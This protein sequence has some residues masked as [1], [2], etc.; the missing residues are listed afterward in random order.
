MA[1]A[2]YS[3]PY[4]FESLVLT[5]K[6]LHCTLQ[7]LLKRHNELRKKYRD[8]PGPEAD[9]RSDSIFD[10]LVEITEHPIIADYIINLDL[11]DF[12][13]HNV[14]GPDE[15][16]FLEMSQKISTLIL[17]SRHLAMLSDGEDGLGAKWLRE[18]VRYSF[19]PGGFEGSNFGVG[20][21]LS[22]LSNVESIS[23]P[24][25]WDGYSSLETG[26]Q[27][28]IASLLELLIRRANDENLQN[29]PLQKLQTIT[30]SHAVHADCEIMEHVVPFMAL[31]SV[32]EVYYS[33][34]I[35]EDCWGRKLMLGP[36]GCNME[37]LK[38][39]KLN[40]SGSPATEIF[41]HMRKLRLLAINDV[42]E[43][44][45]GTEFDADHFIREVQKYTFQT[46]ESLVLTTA[47]QPK[48]TNAIESSFRDFIR[49]KHLELSIDFLV[50][51]AEYLE[52]SM[53]PGEEPHFSEA[54]EASM[55]E[56]GSDENHLEE[57]K[58]NIDYED[59][60][61]TANYE[62]HPDDHVERHTNGKAI[63][64]LVSVLPA[65][66][67]TLVLH[68]LAKGYHRACV[69]QMFVQFQELR[70][71]RFPLLKTIEIHVYKRC[72]IHNHL[73]KH[74]EAQ[75]ERIR[76]I[77]ASKGIVA[78]FQVH[79]AQDFDSESMSLTHKTGL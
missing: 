61:S 32:Q 28:P 9:E 64:R 12:K 25:C 3:M 71:E 79:E 5:C 58:R 31:I 43:G 57:Q 21:L 20:F 72:P 33:S 47:V 70:A 8:F 30:A 53:Q 34:C 67:E 76:A 2:R 48:R 65:S 1:I 37:I 66:L 45:H 77:F 27:H 11:E 17:G 26:P 40:T 63:W 59:G 19:R 23:M 16:C 24:Y 36:L 73:I 22:L 69:E 42:Y 29:E 68:V 38:L 35:L 54:V 60:A 4:G 62:Y 6:Q 14:L 18:S 13:W 78:S 74:A 41:Q 56:D 50:D 7:S 51:G 52:S 75:T 39:R 46:L 15:K 10:L 49:L 55:E 44:W